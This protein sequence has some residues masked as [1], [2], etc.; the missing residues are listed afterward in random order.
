MNHV[1]PNWVAIRTGSDLNPFIDALVFVD[2]KDA[3]NAAMCCSDALAEWFE[4]DN[5]GCCYGDALLDAL[6]MNDF[7]FA[8]HF[9]ILDAK[10]EAPS[11]EWERIIS[12]LESENKIA[13]LAFADIVQRIAV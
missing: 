10:R 1:D 13:Y 2:P 5:P 7:D 3:Q 8:C 12:Q 4:A 9:C 11:Q 6:M